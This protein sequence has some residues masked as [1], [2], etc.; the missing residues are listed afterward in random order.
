MKPWATIPSQTES[1]EDFLATGNKYL[2]KI[3]IQDF[4]SHAY[5]LVNKDG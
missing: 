1:M 4:Y 2:K 3:N 5:I